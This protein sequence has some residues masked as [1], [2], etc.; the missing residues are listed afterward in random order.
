MREL[1]AKKLTRESFAAFGQV[2][3]TAGAKHFPINAGLTTR[4]HDLCSVDT[5]DENGRAIVNVFRTKPLPLPHRVTL[6]ERHPLGSQAFIPT[7]DIPF[8]VLVAKGE[9]PLTAK[10]LSLFVTN[11][12]QGINFKKNVWH[13]FQIGIARER[14]FIVIDRGGR[15]ENLEETRIDEEIWIP[16]DFSAT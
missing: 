10:K 3:E 13:H 1:R 12:K 6:M 2:I 4:F 11:G 14:D 15:G 9:P 16:K 8:L 7:D 5:A